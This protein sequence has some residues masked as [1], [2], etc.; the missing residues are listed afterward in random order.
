MLS[1]DYLVR[2]IMQFASVIAKI[3]GLKM[4]GQYQ[5]ALEVIDQSLGE[6]LGISAELANLLDD[7]SL[8]KALTINEVLDLERLGMVAELFKEKGD[9]LNLQKQKMESDNCYLRS[10]NGYLLISSNKDSSQSNELS[11]KIDELILKLMNYDLPEKTILD[12]FCY[13]ENEGKY[14][15]AENILSLLVNL[16]KVNAD[17]QSE[18]ISFY[19]RLLLKSQKELSAG[20]IE[21]KRIRLKLKDM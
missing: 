1:E 14:A 21:E 2:Q 5:V 11:Q 12:L 7:E 18:M 15:K 20:G 10:L 6:L 4:G 17:I 19:K 8:Y 13:Y 9:I 16:P 3:M